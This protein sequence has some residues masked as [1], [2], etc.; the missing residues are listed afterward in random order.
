MH[1]NQDILNVCRYA[2]TGTTTASTSSAV[3]TF[4]KLRRNSEE[5]FSLLFPF[6]LSSLILFS[7][8]FLPFLVLLLL[9]FFLF[10]SKL[11]RLGALC[12]YDSTHG[13]NVYPSSSAAAL[14]D[15]ISSIWMLEKV[16][17]QL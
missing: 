7:L 13:R 2:L 8:F 11:M 17:H 12:K 6:S 16:G 1:M 14:G 15:T 4:F 5:L 9:D 3:R 10:K